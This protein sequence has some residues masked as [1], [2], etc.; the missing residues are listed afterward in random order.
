MSSL[1]KLSFFVKT[2]SFA[3]KNKDGLQFLWKNKDEL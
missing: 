3:K 2:V 1:I